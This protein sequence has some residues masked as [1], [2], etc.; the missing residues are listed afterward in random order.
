MLISITMFTMVQLAVIIP[1]V[2]TS[3][4]LRES[5]Q[6]TGDIES[7][8]PLSSPMYKELESMQD[9]LSEHAEVR[10]SFLIRI[11]HPDGY[12]NVCHLL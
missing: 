8:E 9:R 11:R 4:C 10:M 3:T 6:T 7:L 12:M 1:S 2:A 5:E